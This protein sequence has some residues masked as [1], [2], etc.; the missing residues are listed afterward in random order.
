LINHSR[1]RAETQIAIRRAVGNEEGIPR[2]EQSIEMPDARLLPANKMKVRAGGRICENKRIFLIG[3]SGVGEPAVEA[4][5][6]S[7]VQAVRKPRRSEDN[8][9]RTFTLRAGEWIWY[10]LKGDER[11]DARAANN[12]IRAIRDI[13]AGESKELH[14]VVSRLAG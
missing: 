13:V 4:G 8:L 2:G 12:R 3:C 7:L 10:R 9:I 6:D 5:E 11:L 1:A 14:G